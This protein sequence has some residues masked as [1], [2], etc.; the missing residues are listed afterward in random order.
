MTYNDAGWSVFWAQGS[1]R[2]SPPSASALRVGKHVGED[3]DTTRND[4]TI[5]YTVVESGS[6]SVDGI[7]YTAGLG[8]DIVRGMTNTPPY[9]YAIATPPSPTT[10]VVGVAAID[11]NDGGWPVLYGASPVSA[12]SLV[13]A[14]DED[15]VGDSE[16]NHTTEQVAYMVFDNA[17]Q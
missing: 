2:T 9:N 1:S 15:Q 7:S 4:E 11:G 6:G 16:R 14:F 12:G 8:A 13:L 3:T 5:G 10:A 17:G